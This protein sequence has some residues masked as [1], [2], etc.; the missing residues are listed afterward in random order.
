M[1]D[2]G[3]ACLNRLF[4]DKNANNNNFDVVIINTH[5]FDISGLDIAKEIH[6]TSPNQRIVIISNGSI[7]HLSKEQLYFAGIGQEEIL[8]IPFR[9][10]YIMSL[11]KLN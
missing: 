1:V 5:L 11:L 6:K 3:E 10:S 7:Q 2:S 4:K 8:T 9:F